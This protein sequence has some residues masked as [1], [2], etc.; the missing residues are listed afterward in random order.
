MI[1]NK[2]F[3]LTLILSS[4]VFR[5]LDIFSL[6][7]HLTVFSFNHTEV[8]EIAHISNQLTCIH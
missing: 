8:S 4:D 5:I 3:D 7:N 2:N 1:K 6:L